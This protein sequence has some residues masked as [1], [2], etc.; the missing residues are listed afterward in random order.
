MFSNKLVA[1]SENGWL[2]FFAAHFLCVFCFSAASCVSLLSGA[3]S[4]R[5]AVPFCLPI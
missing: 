1:V 5:G 4:C 3:M 2:K